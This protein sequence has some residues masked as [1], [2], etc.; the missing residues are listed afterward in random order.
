VTL[1]LHSHTAA[2][3][4]IFCPITLLHLNQ[5]SVESLQF[6]TASSTPP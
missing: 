3:Y 6:N 5:K 2:A 4:T 1:E